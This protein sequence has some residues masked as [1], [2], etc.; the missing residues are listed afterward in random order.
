M[1]LSI[2][3]V[4]IG[5][6]MLALTG[7]FAFLMARR[8]QEFLK[9]ERKPLPPRGFILAA[10]LVT[11]LVYMGAVAS[12]LLMLFAPF[13]NLNLTGTVDGTTNLLIWL[14]L[15]L[16]IFGTAL[17]WLFVKLGLFSWKSLSLDN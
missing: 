8:Q 11:I 17:Y 1:I 16:A 3:L 14:V 13:I 9:Q 4:V 2:T 6:V 7:L 12:A 15:G 10:G 5:L